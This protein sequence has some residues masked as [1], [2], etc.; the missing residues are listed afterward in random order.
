MTYT[1]GDFIVHGR[2]IGKIIAITERDSNKYYKFQSINDPTLTVSTPVARAKT[3]LRPIITANEAQALIDSLPTIE[4]IEV[5]N[6]T[7]EQAYN[8]LVKSGKHIDIVRLIKTTYL[9]CADRKSRGLTSNEKDKVF[10]RLA[11]RLLYSELAIALGKT[12]DETRQYVV[13]RASAQMATA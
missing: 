11:E 8:N 5:E 12:Y 3:N 4:P 2:E 1:I 10:L 13:E 7:I 9:R 6:R